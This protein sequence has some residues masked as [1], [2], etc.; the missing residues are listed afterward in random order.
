MRLTSSLDGKV[1][2]W[3][4]ALY[5]AADDAAV[6]AMAMARKEAKVG[7]FVPVFDKI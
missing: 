4:I 7:N 1:V 5:A 2:N 6:R 3:A